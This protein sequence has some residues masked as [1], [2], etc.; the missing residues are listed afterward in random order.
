MPDLLTHFLSGYILGRPVSKPAHRAI[1]CLGAVLPDMASR[2]PVLFLDIILNRYP[3]K[4]YY[5]FSNLHSPF[6]VIW[7]SLLI[8]LFFA[9][10]RAA[11]FL[12]LM[13]GA[14]FHLFLDFLQKHFE[15]VYFWLFP[16]LWKSGELRMFWADDSLYAIPFLVG[17][18]VIIEGW[19]YLKH[20]RFSE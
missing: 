6:V 15:P 9:R 4:F 20:K 19:I 7:I 11:I 3:G 14:G 1:F 16:F 12:I 5:F 10:E 2:I 8:S 18:I 13:T 17:F